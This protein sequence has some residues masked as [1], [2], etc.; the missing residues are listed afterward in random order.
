MPDHQKCIYK[1]GVCRALQCTF[2]CKNGCKVS[3]HNAVTNLF[4][5]VVFLSEARRNSRSV[6]CKIEHSVAR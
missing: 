2:H 3:C 6:N 4:Q 1:Y 5:Q